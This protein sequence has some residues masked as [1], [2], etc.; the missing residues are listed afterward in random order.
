MGEKR[1]D[2]I[3]MGGENAKIQD[4]NDET[5]EDRTFHGQGSQI[6]VRWHWLKTSQYLLME[7]ST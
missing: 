1:K 5:W 3:T 6:S 2:K 7:R 4:L